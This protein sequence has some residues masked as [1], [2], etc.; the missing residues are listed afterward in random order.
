MDIKTFLAQHP[1]LQAALNRFYPNSPYANFGHT[2]DT[3]RTA[4]LAYL[5]SERSYAAVR[6][7]QGN[8]PYSYMPT[9]WGDVGHGLVMADFTTPEL[10][11]FADVYYGYLYNAKAFPGGDAKG[12]ADSQAVIDACVAELASRGV[13]YMPPPDH[14]RAPTT[15]PPVPHNNG[16]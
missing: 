3:Q 4:A 8:D 12:V 11:A 7:S 16:R 5:D 13:S 9:A 10:V 15:V 6:V 14:D 2:E 1:D